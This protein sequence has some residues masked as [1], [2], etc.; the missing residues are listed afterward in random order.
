MELSVKEL[1]PFLSRQDAAR[2]LG[3]SAKTLA[4]WA[5]AGRG[6]TFYRLG[7]KVLYPTKDLIAWI[8]EN[9]VKIH[10]AEG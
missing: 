2:L 7:R 8:E 1:P 9:V 4:N 3:L 6:P 5:S 10:T